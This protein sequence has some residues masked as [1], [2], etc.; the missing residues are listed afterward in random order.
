MSPSRHRRA[1]RGPL[2]AGLLALSLLASGLIGGTAAQAAPA[3]AA[4]PQAAPAPAPAAAAAAEPFSVL[5]FSKTA[6]FRHDSIPAGIAAIQKLGAD[7]GF[8][9]D[10]T[11]DGGRVQRRQPGQVPGGDLALHHR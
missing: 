9:V 11:E 6:G 4:L 3:A 8:T 5:V 7:N 2:G 10:A 1:R